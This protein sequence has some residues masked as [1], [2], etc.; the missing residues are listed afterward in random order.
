MGCCDCQV[1]ST[2]FGFKNGIVTDG[3]DSRPERIR[4][5]VEQSLARM[6]TDYIDLL[7]QHRVDPAVPMEEVA[8]AVKDLIA[9]GKVRYFGLSEASADAIR[10][11]HTVQPV[12][13]LQSEYSLW[14][15][16]PKTVIFPVLRELGIGFVPFSPLGKGF[17][18][19]AMTTDTPLADDDFR[20]N[21]P[22]FQKDAMRHNAALLEVMDAV[23]RRHGA[24]K[25]Q[26]ALAWVLA[27]QPW[28][29]PIPGTTKRHRL[30]ENLTAVNIALTAAD[31]GEL[32]EALRRIEIVGHRY[33]A[34]SQ[35]M[36]T[37]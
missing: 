23:A 15:R 36:V 30:E 4:A 18:T 8:G 37:R 6:N 26:I 11:A 10:R 1:R 34:A 2:K 20:K 5:V 9:A 32:D 22:R 28:I 29:A 33:T 12:S 13:A 21:L 25:A 31:L 35:R 3:L 16:E 17:L 27:Q 7:Y 19:G 14:W 24:T